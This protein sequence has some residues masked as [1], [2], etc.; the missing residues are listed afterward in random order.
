M[1]DKP[2]GSSVTFN[3]RAETSFGDR[4]LL[5]GSDDALGRWNLDESVELTTTEKDYPLWMSKSIEV[6]EP[7][8]YKYVRMRGD[9]EAVWEFDGGNRCISPADLSTA[10]VVVDDGFFGE[11]IGE[12]FS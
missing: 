1:A 11:L 5:V 2:A 12:H 7:T 6:L 3:V 8:E 10:S 4:L 9:G